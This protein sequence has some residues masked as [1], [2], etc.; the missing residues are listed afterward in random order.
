MGAAQ[1][2][3][4]R[5]RHALH[6]PRARRRLVGTEAAAW[7][8]HAV[9]VAAA[10]LAVLYLWNA[11]DFSRVYLFRSLLRE[12]PHGYAALAA[13]L[14]PDE[15]YLSWNVRTASILTYVYGR[16]TVHVDRY[17]LGMEELPILG[18]P[19]GKS[20]GSALLLRQR[21]WSPLCWT[22]VEEVEGAVPGGSP[23]ECHDGSPSR[24]SCS[25][26]AGASTRTA[27]RV[28]PAASSTAGGKVGRARLDPL[29]G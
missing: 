21:D 26:A 23:R 10:A 20:W 19:P 6:R 9:A 5:S 28:L 27:S 2:A 11:F 7:P 29:D 18:A 3:S 8:A 17:V 22:Y 16:P 4:G 25:T 12:L 14:R 13:R 24:S 1:K 15:T